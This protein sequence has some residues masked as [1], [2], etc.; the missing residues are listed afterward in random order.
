MVKESEIGKKNRRRVRHQTKRIDNRQR[1]NRQTIEQTDRQTDEDI[2][3]QMEK[4]WWYSIYLL[5]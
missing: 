1:K 5:L 2:D 3:K 4:A